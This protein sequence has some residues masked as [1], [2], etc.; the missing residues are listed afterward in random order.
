MNYIERNVKSTSSY[1][2]VTLLQNVLLYLRSLKR[3]NKN[4]FANKYCTF[5]LFLFLRDLKFHLSS[6]NKAFLGNANKHWCLP[7]PAGDL[8][9]FLSVRRRVVAAT[10]SA[11]AAELQVPQQEAAAS[12]GKRGYR[13]SSDTCELVE[14]SF[15]PCS[16][17]RAGEVTRIHLLRP[18]AKWFGGRYYFRS[19]LALCVVI[20]L[21]TGARSWGV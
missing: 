14:K 12:A 3:I 16:L 6:P 8:S 15:P 19:Y 11:D 5:F 18:G 17:R 10:P 4:V 1:K 20:Q 13:C 2:G 21:F 9:P 7:D